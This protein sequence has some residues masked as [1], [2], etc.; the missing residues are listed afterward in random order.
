MSAARSYLY[1]P[2]DHPDRLAKALTCSADALIVDLEDA[3]LP[4][5]KPA[6]GLSE[7]LCEGLGVTSTA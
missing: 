6:A 2:G 4:Q 7:I 5:A 3:V 1:V